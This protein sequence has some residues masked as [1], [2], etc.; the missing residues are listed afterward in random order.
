M[1]IGELGKQMMI[2]QGYVPSTCTLPIEIA[3]P[4]IWTETNAGRD[5]C[6]RCNHDRNICKGRPK[7]REDE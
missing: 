7:N 6:A 2:Q 3:G 4:V 1:F 5:V